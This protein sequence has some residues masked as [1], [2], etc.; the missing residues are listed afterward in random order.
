MLEKIKLAVDDS[1]PNNINRAARLFYRIK[2]LIYYKWVFGSFG[3]G[4]YVRT[5]CL[6]TNL[7]FMHIGQNSFLAK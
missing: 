3:S 1:I 5:P 7:R 2:A 6:L 4:S